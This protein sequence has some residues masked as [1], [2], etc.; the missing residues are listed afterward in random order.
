MCMTSRRSRRQHPVVAEKH[1]ADGGFEKTRRSINP[2]KT[3]ESEYIIDNNRISIESSRYLRKK[4][5]THVDSQF[6]P[7]PKQRSVKTLDFSCDCVDGHPAI[8]ADV[9]TSTFVSALWCS[10][11][12]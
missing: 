9:K 6:Y 2:L 12:F 4:M 3:I 7:S 1:G 5:K 8:P 11:T 10:K